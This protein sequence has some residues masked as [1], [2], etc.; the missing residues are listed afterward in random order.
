M[1]RQS[2][3]SNPMRTAWSLVAFALLIPA[4]SICLGSAAGA[5][6]RLKIAQVTNLSRAIDELKE[7]GIWA[8][9]LDAGAETAYDKADLNRPL[10]LV[11][12]GE[13]KGLR[14]LVKQHCDLVIS[15][16]MP[17]AIESLNAGSRSSR[18]RSTTWC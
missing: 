15:L 2:T 14:H 10:A 13:G 6:E 9:G 17:G 16:P 7:A 1:P 12:G 5:I 11:V 8:V 4:L 18:F 3:A